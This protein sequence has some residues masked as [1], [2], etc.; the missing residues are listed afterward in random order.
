MIFPD[1]NIKLSYS[2]IGCGAF[3]LR[4]LHKPQTVSLLWEKAKR[5][6]MLNNYDKFLLT[7]DFLYMI[8]VIDIQDG[9]VIRGRK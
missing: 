4:C 5:S 6:E 2:I 8:N 9:M 1:K 3:L 7:L